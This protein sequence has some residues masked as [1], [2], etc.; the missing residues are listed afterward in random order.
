MAKKGLNNSNPYNSVNRAYFIGNIG[1]ICLADIE[2]SICIIS[3]RFIKQVF[4]VYIIARKYS[5]NSGE[6]IR[7]I[8]VYNANSAFPAA[9]HYNFR[10]VYGINDITVFNIVYK[11]LSRHSRAVI[12]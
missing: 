9:R 7:N 5:R 6:H 3:A 8:F 11:L 12:L 1:N 4:N 10:Q 2:H